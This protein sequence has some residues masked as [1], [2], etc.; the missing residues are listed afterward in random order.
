MTGVVGKEKERK[1]KKSD[2]NFCDCDVIFLLWRPVM[3]EKEKKENEKR[4][5]MKKEARMKKLRLDTKDS[6]RY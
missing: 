4:M 5:K 2:Y 6:D 1:W 3:W